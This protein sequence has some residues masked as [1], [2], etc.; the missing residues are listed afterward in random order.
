[1]WID[2]GAYLAVAGKE[3]SVGT[4]NSS[5]TDLGSCLPYDLGEVPKTH[6]LAINGSLENT[7]FGVVVVFYL[8]ALNSLLIGVT[9]DPHQPRS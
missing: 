6:W 5:T 3:S 8:S 7:G 2:E 4:G 1:M 9:Y